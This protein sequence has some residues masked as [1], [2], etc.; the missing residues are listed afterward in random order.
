[1]GKVNIPRGRAAR[2]FRGTGVEPKGSR[3]YY[4]L[5]AGRGDRIFLG[6]SCPLVSLVPGDGDDLIGDARSLRVPVQETALTFLL[7][8]ASGL[9]SNA[10]QS[11][12]VMG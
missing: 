5:A 9:F 2:L 6:A 11:D 8:R 10:T 7:S 12:S 1:M 4:D 3:L